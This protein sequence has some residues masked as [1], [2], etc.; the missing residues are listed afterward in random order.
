MISSPG[1]VT[2]GFGLDNGQVCYRPAVVALK[3]Y[4]VPGIIVR[5][6][7]LVNLSG[8][9]SGKYPVFYGYVYMFPHPSALLPS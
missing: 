1:P 3:D 2:A 9:Q 5:W 6:R 8:Y 4:L 7:T